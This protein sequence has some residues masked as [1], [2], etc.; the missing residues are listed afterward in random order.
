MFQHREL[1]LIQIY[2]LAVTVLVTIVFWLYF[3]TCYELFG[4]SLGANYENYLEYFLAILLG[5]QFSFLRNKQSDIFSITLGV[6]ESHRFISPHIFFI[7]GITLLFLLLFR[8]GEISFR[9]LISY[10]VVLYAVLLI[11]TRYLAFNFL[12]WV[13]RRNDQ[14]LLLVGRPEEVEL[15]EPLL[16]KAR[17][18][19]FEPIGLVTESPAEALPL[20]LKKLG[21]PDE[22]ERI[23]DEQN[24]N[25]I[26]ILGSPRDRRV[27]G[28]W[29]RMAEARGCRVSLVNDL[30]VFLQRKLSYFRCN[31]VDLIE[32][33]AE[34]LQNFVNRTV[35]RSLDIFAGLIGTCVVLPPLILLVW[36]LQR[37]QAPG[38]LFFR[39][40]RSG[41]GNHRFMILKFRTMYARSE[42]SGKQATLGD[43]RIFPAGR[44][45]RKFSI[46]EFPQFINVLFGT[47]SVVGPRPHI[48]QHDKMFAEQM[49]AYRVR[50]F[51]KPGVTGLAQIRGFRGEVVNQEDVVKRIECDLEYIE[52]WNFILDIRI[53]WRTILNVIRPPKTAF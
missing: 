46:D 29:M 11:F 20:G 31:D 9:F 47:M 26:F 42:D 44:L 3:Y 1:G 37:F 45:L 43:A 10:L 38:P 12:Y 50:G 40:E 19:G 34:P 32:L 17:L 23:V 21:G 8:S 5:L 33:R 7:T 15:L 52:S 53:I 14:P 49:S 24:V 25:N 39:Q 13:F 22:L 51:V 6:E 41:V 30:D 36:I 2:Q 48:L 35:K 28:D 4:S 18:F 27:L 16:A